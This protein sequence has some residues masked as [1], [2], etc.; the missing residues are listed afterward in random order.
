MKPGPSA[1]ES[2]TLTTRLSS[3]RDSVYELSCV[4][5]DRRRR[6]VESSSDMT[7]ADRQFHSTPSSARPSLGLP[8]AGPR[9]PAHSVHGGRWRRRHGPGT[10]SLG[11]SVRPLVVVVV[12]HASQMSRR[13]R[14]RRLAPAA[15]YAYVRVL[16]R[17]SARARASFPRSPTRSLASAH[18]PLRHCAV[19]TVPT[20]AAVSLSAVVASRRTSIVKPRISECP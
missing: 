1:P 10:S 18:P 12:V 19:H 16:M 5:T 17:P 3:H 13:R 9:H 2:S 11:P 7:A 6:R 20:H 15:R 8:R 14:R 4:H